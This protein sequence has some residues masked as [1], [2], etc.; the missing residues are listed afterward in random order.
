MKLLCSKSMVHDAL[1]PYG[2]ARRAGNKIRKK[3]PRKATSEN[4]L[5]VCT[6]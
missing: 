5:A 3:H 4:E 1:I 2:S 6:S